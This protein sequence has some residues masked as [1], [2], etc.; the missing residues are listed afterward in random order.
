MT[1]TLSWHYG[2]NA[3]LKKKRGF[4][5]TAS[6]LHWN[7]LFFFNFVLIGEFG[8]L[9]HRRSRASRNVGLAKNACRIGRSCSLQIYKFYT[10][11]SCVE[12]R[13]TQPIYWKFILKIILFCEVSRQHCCLWLKSTIIGRAEYLN[14]IK[15]SRFQVIRYTGLKLKHI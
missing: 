7:S 15:T 11:K 12:P 2:R 10:V 3:G 9:Y 8:S 13:I 6:P 1:A 4:P 5:H 14:A